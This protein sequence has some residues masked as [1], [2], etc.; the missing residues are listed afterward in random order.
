MAAVDAG[1][2]GGRKVPTYNDD[3]NRCKT[4]LEEFVRTD[5]N[6]TSSYKDQLLAVANRETSTI[7]IEVDDV[8]EYDDSLASAIVENTRRYAEMFARAIDSIAME[9]TSDASH[10][11]ILDIF[12]NH[13]KVHESMN[14]QNDSPSENRQRYPPALLRRY[15]VVFNAPTPLSKKGGTKSIRQIEA[16]HIG[17]LVVV[18]G[19]VIRST[20]V[21]PTIT[22][23]TYTCD[24]CASDN[25]QTITGPTYMPKN[26]CSS[27]TCTQNK[28]KGRL[29]LQ[30]R[31]SKFEKFQELKIQELSR[32]VPT[33]HIPRTMTIYAKGDVTRLASPGD[34]VTVTGIFLPIVKTGFK[35]IRG[36][37]L[38][39][40]FL[41]AQ[42]IEK[43]KKNYDEQ[44]EKIDDEERAELEDFARDPD[45]YDKLASSISPAIYGHDD[46]KKALLLLLIGGVD[47]KLSDGMHIRGCVNVCLVGDPGVAKS[48]MLKAVSELAPRGIYTTGRGSSGV[49]LTAAITKDQ[50]TGELILEGGALVLADMGVCC[51]DEFDK[52]DESDRTSIHEVME[53]Q[54]VSIAKAGI[55]TS[56]NARASILAAANPLYGRYNPKKTAAQNI[57]LPT[58]LLSRFDLLFL[59]LDRPDLDGDLR[60]AH[61]ITYVHTHND[62]PPLEHA[63]VPR[64]TV[65]NY[66]AIARGYQPYISKELTDFIVGTYVKLREDSDENPDIQYTGARTLL[67]VL[68]C[69]TALARLRMD[70]E[71]TQADVEEAL[72]LMHSSKASLIDSRTATARVVEPVND[73]YNILR[74][75][76]GE[77]NSDTISYSDAERRAEMKGYQP[78]DF[79][80]CLA[81]YE[82]NNVIMV[83]EQRSRIIFV[84]V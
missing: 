11:S 31:G 72:R 65:R 23:A 77:A 15:Q 52:M 3:T 46:V 84:D 18:E 62:F 39:D 50:F 2:A 35:A 74:S 20:P 28:R 83:N 24:Q 9:P 29:V 38:S 1:Q 45:V 41:E 34:Q 70:N 78:H 17:K 44:N 33:G 80:E 63:P 48:Q 27:A 82:D 22:V 57:N 25:Y 53:Q 66:I 7:T 64:E 69:S 75:M 68:R 37:L 4:F 73:I 76:K 67:A 55:T 71:V 51:I 6:Q 32:H 61:H 30:T 8:Q 43:H 12:I 79:E 13:R 19:I 10:E 16:S 59:L 21:K 58:A 49:G 5:G 47:R 14:A 56:L 54:T 40:T 26:E 60:L 81:T 42:T 36:G